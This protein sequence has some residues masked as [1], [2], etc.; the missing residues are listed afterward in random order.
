MQ[1]YTSKQLLP[2]HNATKLPR[3]AAQHTMSDNAHMDIRRSHTPSISSRTFVIPEPA[4]TRSSHERTPSQ[5]DNARGGSYSDSDSSSSSSALDDEDELADD[6]SG[7]G[8]AHSDAAESAVS[9]G[10][11]EASTDEFLNE[12]IPMAKNGSVLESYGDEA[13]TAMID[14][15][16]YI[17][18]SLSHAMENVDF[19]ETLALQT[20]MSGTINFKSLELKELIDQTQTTLAQLRQRYD[21]GIIV[22]NK[23]R[24][25]IAY[26]RKK[27]EEINSLLRTDFPIEFNEARD[28]ILERH[29]NDDK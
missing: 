29:F 18:D 13:P 3:K 24:D 23:L 2:P 7:A 21:S 1:K 26:S 12:A 10:F 9:S 20:K 16:K 14:V 6:G 25:N 27:I 28:K 19:S 5:D 8:D 15:S 22:S 4:E 11:T 17:F